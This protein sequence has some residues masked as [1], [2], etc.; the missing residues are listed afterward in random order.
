MKFS[1]TRA[2]KARSSI[3]VVCVATVLPCVAWPLGAQS[4]DSARTAADSARRIERVLVRAIRA[5]DAAPIA[6][7]TIDRAEIRQRKSFL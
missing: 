4:Q 2:R 3:A 6:Q 1:L 5:S 7:K